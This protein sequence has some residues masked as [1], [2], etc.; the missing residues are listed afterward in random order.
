LTE[1]GLLTDKRDLIMMM[2][3]MK[4]ARKLLLGRPVNH[5][6]STKPHTGKSI[7]PT[8]TSANDSKVDCKVENVPLHCFEAVPGTLFGNTEELEGFAHYVK[9]VG[10]TYFHVSGTCA[11]ETCADGDNMAVVDVNLRVRGVRNLRVGDASIFPRITSSPTSA[12]C[13]AVGVTLARLI[14]E[15]GSQ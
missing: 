14:L 1:H 3:G 2:N 6:T 4:T 12:T 10:N 13:M 15:A 11:M 5:S 7:S 8:T 9:H